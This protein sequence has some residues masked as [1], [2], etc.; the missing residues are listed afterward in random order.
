M[1]LVMRGCFHLQKGESRMEDIILM[2][3]F[4]VLWLFIKHFCCTQ[5]EGMHW[6]QSAAH[7]MHRSNQHHSLALLTSIPRLNMSTSVLC[8]YVPSASSPEDVCPFTPSRTKCKEAYSAFI[9]CPQCLRST[10]QNSECWQMLLNRMD[11]YC[12]GKSLYSD[13]L[14][15][16]TKTTFQVMCRHDRDFA[17]PPS[18]SL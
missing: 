12:Q 18:F 3:I 5:T 7:S 10:K 2:K 6:G 1:I 15:G 9:C 16:I 8:Q 4:T 11:L 13:H 14:T 17:P